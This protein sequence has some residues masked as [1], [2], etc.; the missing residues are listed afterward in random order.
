MEAPCFGAYRNI[1]V[2]QSC[3]LIHVCIETSIHGDG[4]FDELDRRWREQW[5]ETEQALQDGATCAMSL[6]QAT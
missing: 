2:C 4:Y 1:D 5:E 6:Q 3:P